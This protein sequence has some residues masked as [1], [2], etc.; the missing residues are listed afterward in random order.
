LCLGL[1]TLLKQSKKEGFRFGER[2][3]N[4]YKKVWIFAVKSLDAVNQWFTMIGPDC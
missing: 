2:L 1:D 3:L 4:D